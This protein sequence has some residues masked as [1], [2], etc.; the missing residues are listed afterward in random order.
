MKQSGFLSDSS[1]RS[2]LVIVFPPGVKSLF[3]P[4]IHRLVREVEQRL[5]DVF[6]TYALSGG[7]APDV[8]SAVNAARF[9][10][11]SSAI[12]VHSEDWVGQGEWIAPGRDTVLTENH[13]STDIEEIVQRVVEAY[14]QARTAEHKAA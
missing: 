11:C 7:A 2:G 1:N 10:G 12:V 8:G 4:G 13:D 9:A 5:G 14:S 3:N 6:V